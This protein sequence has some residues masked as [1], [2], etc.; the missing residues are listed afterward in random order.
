MNITE[1]R[2]R[3]V[4]DLAIPLTQLAGLTCG[5][6][7]YI[8]AS[9]D[10]WLHWI[11]CLDVPINELGSIFEAVLDQED[12][13]KRVLGPGRPA[14][15]KGSPAGVQRAPGEPRDPVC[16]LSDGDL[17]NIQWSG[18][19][20]TVVVVIT[21]R[22]VVLRDLTED[23]TAQ[24]AAAEVAHAQEDSSTSEGLSNA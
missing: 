14:S 3:L 4:S 10:E 9:G 12:A 7:K 24:L 19:I 18:Q 15:M 17:L 2:E 8:G 6:R 11:D 1:E 22:N 20:R 5:M 16:T 21:G 13:Y 23:E